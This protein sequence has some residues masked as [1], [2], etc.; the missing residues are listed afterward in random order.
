MNEVLEV[1][2]NPESKNEG[3]GLS[4]LSVSDNLTNKSQSSA[5]ADFGRAFAHTLVQAPIEG[6]AQLIDGKVDGAASKAVHFL[7]APEQAQFMSSNWLAQQTGNALGAILPVL[8]VHKGVNFGLTRN[9]SAKAALAMTENVSALTTRQ[10]F[11]AGG[12]KMA[13]AGITGAIYSG[14]F[15]PTHKA[16][17]DDFAGARIRHTLVGAT[18]FATLAGTGFGMKAASEALASKTPAVARVLGNEVFAGVVSG[19]PAGLVSANGES[20]LAGR[21]FAKFE[22][23]VKSV[24]TFSLMG[25]G[26]AYGKGRLAERVPGERTTESTGKFKEAGLDVDGRSIAESQRANVTRNLPEYSEGEMGRGRS[27]TLKDLSEIKAL[28][29]GK[30]VLDQFRNSGLSI[31]QKYRV[32]SSLTEV[33]EHF[34]NQRTNGRIDPDQQ[35]N[36]IHTQGEFGKVMSSAKENGLTR[37][38]TEDAL[39]GSMFADAVKA[40]ANFHTHHMDGALAADH[41]LSKHFGAGFDRTRLDGVVH[42]IREHQV[43]PPAFMANVMYAGKIKAALGFKL[44]PE[45]EVDLGTLTKKISDPL[46]SETVQLPDGSTAL[47]LTAGEKALLKLTGVNEWYVPKEGNAWNP[48]SRAIIDGDTIDNYSTPGGVGKI[49]SL[50]GAETDVYF[51]NVRLD[52]GRGVVDRSS[53]IGSA[54]ASNQDAASLLTPKGKELAG[55]GLAQTEAAIQAAKERVADWLVTEKKVDPAKETVPFLNGDLKYPSRSTPALENEWW[56]IHRTPA[57]KRT[58]EQQALYDRHRFDG[59]TPKEQADFLQSKEIRERVVADLRAAQRLD[60]QQPRDYQPST[61][62]KPKN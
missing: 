34:V 61:G 52:S 56:N 46:R 5:V 32:L 44:T 33:R 9:Y 10:A 41:V 58:V 39:L 12:L 55:Q 2:N 31:S 54:R 21:G 49:A 36:W 62:R 53:N 45:Q 3:N 60:G 50:G 1:G 6:V 38:Q 16:E 22:D 20:L 24:G 28:Q 11:G 42:A 48:S 4:L 27:Q 43:G 51:K 37:F 35:G 25:G 17:A 29:E 23:Q 13:E 47:K 40:K 14:V 15:T 30:S 18:T 57:D 59:L 26:F 7:D 19:V 8:A